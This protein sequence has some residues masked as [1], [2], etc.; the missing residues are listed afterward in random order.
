VPNLPRWSPRGIADILECDDRVVRRGTAD[1]IPADLA[2][3]LETLDPTK[4][5]HTP[6]Y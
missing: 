4:Q 6:K 2:A 3:R 5:K 1:E